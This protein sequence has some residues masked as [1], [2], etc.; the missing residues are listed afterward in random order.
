MSAPTGLGTRFCALATKVDTNER[1]NDT[2]DGSRTFASHCS[3]QGR[4]PGRVRPPGQGR[5]LGERGA[6]SKGDAVFMFLGGGEAENAGQGG[7]LFVKR[8]FLEC[9]NPSCVLVASGLLQCPL[10]LRNGCGP[11]WA[12]FLS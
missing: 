4:F 10:L 12:C 2:R 7:E 6:G 1:V 5:V 9:K 11:G 3:A 8:N